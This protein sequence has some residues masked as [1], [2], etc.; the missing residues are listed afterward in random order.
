MKILVAVIAFNEAGNIATTIRDLQDNNIG[1]DIV[2]IDNG[3][4]DDTVAI[5][6]K[7][8]VKC[9]RHCVNSGGSNGT[10]VSYFLYAYQQ[11]YD[12]LCQFDGDGQHQASELKKILSPVVAGEADC[13][14][15]SRFLERE[16]FQS[17]FFRRLGI[18]LFSFLLSKM[19][20]LQFTDITSGFRAYGPKVIRFYGHQY[21]NAIYDNMNQF[22]LL[23]YYSGA[24][25]KEVPVVMKARAHGTS[26]FNWWN[27]VM[28]P[29]KG[30]VTL[31][32]CYLQRKRIPRY[33]GH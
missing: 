31:L 25:I 4:Y 7:M 8:G 23:A 9:I 20:K 27:G 15:G 1:Y 11:G 16:G 18:R 17:Y 26:E 12:I 24:V 19:T 21:Q 33:V 29:V 22:L 28:F 14:I 32:A 5:A 6:Q 2:V 3:S 10:A 13:V 30:I